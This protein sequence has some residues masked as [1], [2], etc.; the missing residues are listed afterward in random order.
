MKSVT[1]RSVVMSSVS[2]LLHIGLFSLSVSDTFV[3][4]YNTK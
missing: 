2:G 1:M 3:R 4:F